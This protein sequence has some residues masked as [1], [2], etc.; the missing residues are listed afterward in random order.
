MEIV[1]V[2]L[3][4][5]T[6]PVE[7]RERVAFTPGQAKTAS[8][9]LR[10]L[11]ILEESAIL[12]T[13]NRSEIYGVLPEAAS[14]HKQKLDNFYASFH[15]LSTE[16]LKGALYSRTAHAAVRHLYRVAAGL[17]SMLLGEAEVLGQVRSAYRAALDNGTTGRMLNRLFQHA[18][19]VGKQVRNDTGLGVRPVS[20]AFA[21]VKLAEQILGQ[22]GNKKALILGAGAT[23]GRVVGHLRD[24][25]IEHL[26]LLNRT[27]KHAREVA[28]RLGG[29][30]IPW[31]SLPDALEW[32]DLIVTS[33]A[34]PEPILTRDS[35]ERASALRGSRPLL[36]IDLGLPRNVASSA[37]ALENVY[38][39]N[40]DDLTLIVEQ[41]KR[42]REAEIPRAE[43]IVEDHVQKFVQW[44]AGTRC[45]L[46]SGSTPVVAS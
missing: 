4:H 22:L 41:N 33:V 9:S 30:V 35:L 20:V 36:L 10:S 3:N 38:V 21:G 43:A 32:P 15:G 24:R 46:V 7:L 1:V 31:E 6:A 26:R 17:D 12:S 29:E 16:E 27:G 13:C 14:S 5:R 18:L 39:Y 44:H 19:E 42:A 45:P 34:S 28:E 25:G 8:D 2:G 37:S 23:S 40:I 11:G